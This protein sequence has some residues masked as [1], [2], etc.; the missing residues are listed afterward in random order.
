MIQLFPMTA[1][2]EHNH[3]WVSEKVI[4]RQTLVNQYC[5]ELN[6]ST[7]RY[8]IVTPS[9]LAAFYG[10]ATQETMWFGKLYEANKAAR[11]APW[12]GRGFLQLT[13]PDNYIKYW[14]FTGKIIADSLKIQLNK[15]AK[16]AN[17][18]KI[19][20]PLV[21]MDEHIPAEMSKWRQLVEGNTADIYDAANSAGA[22]WVWTMAAKFA[23][24]E[25]PNLRATKII[26]G[27]PKAYY[28]N[29]SFGNVAGTVNIGQP[30]TSYSSVN[31]IVARFQAYTAA[32][33][34]LMDN[35]IFLSAEGNIENHPDEFVPRRS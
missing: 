20:T 9:R 13:W 7:R 19:N 11:Y 4:I 30:T 3:Q 35:P 10:N 28:T 14:E 23:D 17:L 26:N 16:Q 5:T 8:C 33:V 24:K 18:Q 34:V 31:G 25:A 2:R 15:A 22:Y 1:M 27:K 12:D 21:T 6:K 29:G 32:Q